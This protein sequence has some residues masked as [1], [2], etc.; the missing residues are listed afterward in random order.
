MKM[1]KKHLKIASAAASLC[2]IS[3]ATSHAAT[4]ID[5]FSGAFSATTVVILDVNSG[6]SNTATWSTSGG[7]LSYVTSAFDGIEQA[8]SYYSGVTLDIGQELQV[9]VNHTGASQDIGLFVGAVPTTGARANYV[10]VYARDNATVYSRGFNGS[11]ELALAGGA[12]TGTFDRLFILRDA[13]SSYELGYYLTD[14][15]RVVVSDRD[16][17]DAAVNGS[18]VGIYTD[19]RAAGTLG[20]LDNL[21]IIP[22][23]AVALLGGLGLLGLLRRRRG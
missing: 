15:T 21:V 9:N 5:D 8:A 10:N 19:V 16:G 23:P 3:V 2:A 20:S 18:A 22:E 6:A 1:M 17:L 13:A 4:L 11:S 14:G 12:T 7:V